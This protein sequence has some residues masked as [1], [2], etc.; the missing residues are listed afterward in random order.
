MKLRS[1]AASFVFVLA[2]SSMSSRTQTTE[3]ATVPVVANGPASASE[4][5]RIAVWRAEGPAALDRLL[6]EYDHA[7][8][9][10]ARDR[11][12][13]TIDKVAG[14]RYAT[15]SRLYWYDDLEAAKAAARTSGKPILSL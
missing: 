12:A 7:A 8:P 6:A 4:T 15:W 13:R 5:A 9:G 14:Q 2:C 3:R 10:D 11:L 1:L